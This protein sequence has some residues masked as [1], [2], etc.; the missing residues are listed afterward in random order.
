MQPPAIAT[1][2]GIRWYLPFWVVRRNYSF[3]V[4]PIGTWRIDLPSASVLGLQQALVVLLTVISASFVTWAVWRRCRP[5]DSRA[6]GEAQC[7][8]PAEDAAAASKPT[9][10]EN[11]E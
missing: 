7:T 11:Q 10:R 6:V 4:S 1:V 9:T 5:A 8:E 2:L 3:L